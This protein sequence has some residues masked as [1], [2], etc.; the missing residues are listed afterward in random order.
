MSDSNIIKVELNDS[1]KKNI[2]LKNN[3]F[4]KT[5]ERDKKK[6]E[7]IKEEIIKNINK[8]K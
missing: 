2:N 7:R 8:I 4:V 3:G 1:K 6:I 5:L